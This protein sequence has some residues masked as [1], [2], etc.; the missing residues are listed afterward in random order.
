VSERQIGRERPAPVAAEASQH[1]YRGEQGCRNPSSLECERCQEPRAGL[2]EHAV[3]GH[4]LP[5]HVGAALARGL[6]D[7]RRVGLDGVERGNRRDGTR[8]VAAFPGRLDQGVEHVGDPRETLA[9]WSADT[10]AASSTRF[11][12]RR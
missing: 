6:A 11:F 12:A 4:E 9:P 10:V 8:D 3:F 1:P 5:E 2:L 7:Q